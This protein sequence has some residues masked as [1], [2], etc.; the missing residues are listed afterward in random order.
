[1]STK[2]RDSNER[3]HIS[4]GGGAYVERDVQTAGGDFIGRDKIVY[5]DE[6]HGDKVMGDKITVIHQA[7]LTPTVATAPAPPPHFTGRRHHLD[8]LKAAL[9]NSQATTLA[10]QGMGG[11][12]KT[13]T[14]QKLA[15]EVDRDFPGGIFWGSLADHDGEPRPILRAWARACGQDLS[16][17]PDPNA[18]ANLV[19]GFL[20]TRQVKYGPLLLII[21]DVRAKWLNAAK[22]LQRAQ[23]A[24]TPFLLTTRDE[25][26]AAA[27]GAVVHRLDALLPDE[28]LALLKSHAGAAIVEADLRAAQALLAV[29]GYLPL[30]IELAGKRLALWA[31]KPG[32][33]L[34]TLGQDVA[35]RAVE[36]LTL[37]GH[38]GLA[39]TFA[40]TYEALPAEAQQM[41]SWLGV[42]AS[43]PLHVTSV[44]GVLGR[45]EA[46]TE[47]A[48]DALVPSALLAWGAAE[49]TYVLHPLLHQYAQTLLAERGE[50]DKAK[51]SHL[52]YYLAFAQANAQ[53]DPVAHDRLE[54]ALPNLL[55]A[56]DFAAQ[57]EEYQA[58]NAFGHAL[59]EDSHLLDTRGYVREA[60]ALLVKA[61]A[62]C[63]E[64]GDQS[65]EG[66]HLGNLGTTYRTLGQLAQAVD[67]H[68]QALTIARE[69]GD[70][71]GEGTH[72]ANLGL[73]HIALGQM[74]QTIDYTHQALTIARATGDRRG[75]G[76][77]LGYLGL[78]YRDLG[79]A[80]QA[81]DCHQQA[82]AISREMDDRRAEGIHLGNLGLAYRD[83][84]QVTQAID[85]YQQA[86]TI[87]REVGDRRNEGIALGKL[88]TAYRD[89][90]GQ[91]ERAIDYHQQAVAISHEMGDR[92]HEAIWLGNLGLDHRDLGQVTRAIDYTQ[93]ALAIVRQI[94]DHRHEGIHLG[95]LGLAYHDLGHLEQAI[96]YY[97][98]ALANSRE[99]GDRL[100]EGMHL[101]N[102]GCAYYDLGQAE[103]AIDY[104][105]QAL[106]ILEEI[107]S[108][109]AEPIHKRLS[110]LKQE[111]QHQSS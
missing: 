10:L 85:C 93:Q 77:C 94:G 58:V 48:L 64:I 89:D 88:G 50:A 11:I 99:I 21:D 55:V 109:K 23:P 105:Q 47:V 96:D 35:Q 78:A 54:A 39:A 25:T 42:F 28:A 106:T 34:A 15:L 45:T 91:V 65:S 56:V 1:M 59:Y 62:A 83:L 49:G 16:A 33:R 4:T 18:L 31:R 68:K 30:A 6:I 14:V 2:E 52:A 22:L 108:P 57:A 63:R 70:R 98:Q 79:Q 107:K 3:Q 20:S 110:E 13:A 111:K 8:T 75:E 27:L 76:T 43:G 36:A 103:K 81:L 7:P 38:P 87:A 44:A 67:A 102:L 82:L 74:T 90:L 101:G 29:M 84:G 12:G 53:I 61:A 46:E 69:I 9:A 17:E 72:L 41:F 73:D 32:Y 95:N 51:H 66:T 19:R 86:L 37:P 97:Q 40:I 5:G 92:R 24:D 60:A 100:T 26:V 104:Y 80:A 71:R